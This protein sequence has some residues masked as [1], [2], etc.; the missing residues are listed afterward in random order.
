[1]PAPI[2]RPSALAK[3][4]DCGTGTVPSAVPCSIRTG[5]SSGV[6]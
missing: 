3:R 4:F 6:M 5:G 2:T 1:M